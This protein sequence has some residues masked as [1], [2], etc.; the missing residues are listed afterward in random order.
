MRLASMLTLGIALSMAACGAGDEKTS[1]G[2]AA[3]TATLFSIH[4]NVCTLLTPQKNFASETLASLDA[5][6]TAAGASAFTDGVCP[7]TVT[8]ETS[9]ATVIETCDAVKKTQG[10]AEYSLRSSIYNAKKTDAGVVV[11]SKEEAS[12]QCKSLQTP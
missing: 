5:E 6:A 3:S 11:V 8:V 4:N 2:G 7:N 10:A 12:E 9:K 1:G